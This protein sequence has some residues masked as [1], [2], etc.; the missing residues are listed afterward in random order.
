MREA[1]RFVRSAQSRPLARQ[2]RHVALEVVHHGESI[3][4]AHLDLQHRDLEVHRGP[5]P[6][7]RHIV[8]AWESACRPTCL[9]PSGETSPLVA[10]SN[11]F[12]AMCVRIPVSLLETFAQI[13]SSTA[14][15]STLVAA[16]NTRCPVRESPILA[17]FFTEWDS[18]M[19]RC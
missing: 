3:W 13:S 10:A 6:D 9:N 4:I 7:Q 15:K 19:K 2:D 8:G 5:S 11:I 14:R 17:W 18:G 16:S 12:M 1:S